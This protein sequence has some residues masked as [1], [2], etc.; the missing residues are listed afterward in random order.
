MS[1]HV[2]V[3]LKIGLCA[4]TSVQFHIYIYIYIYIYSTCTVQVAEVVVTLNDNIAK[5][6]LCAIHW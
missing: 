4:I 3:K 6:I 1:F 2:A 5:G